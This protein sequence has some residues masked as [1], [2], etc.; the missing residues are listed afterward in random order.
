MEHM[1]GS[2]HKTCTL[3]P[4]LAMVVYH[5]HMA[6]GEKPVL[7]TIFRMTKANHWRV[8][9]IGSQRFWSAQTF[10]PQETKA[11]VESF[12]AECGANLCVERKWEKSRTCLLCLEGLAP[13]FFVVNFSN[14]LIRNILLV[15][16]PCVCLERVLVSCWRPTKSY[17][18]ALKSHLFYFAFS[19]KRA[20]VLQAVI[21][22]HFHSSVFV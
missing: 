6:V 14:M 15:F 4:E 2:K 11:Q 12:V 20:G 21:F 10:L 18:R 7:T 9:F 22:I 17:T 19:L 5:F 1:Y 3:G 16:A 13:R 8:G